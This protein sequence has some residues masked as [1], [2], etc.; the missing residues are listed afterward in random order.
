MS[1]ELDNPIIPQEYPENGDLEPSGYI[2]H[3]FHN[4]LG[5]RVR[6]DFDIPEEWIIF[7]N[8][9]QKTLVGQNDTTVPPMHRC[10]EEALKYDAKAEFTQ[11]APRK[12][13][14]ETPRAESFVL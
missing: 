8:I 9:V 3:T 12:I 10:M 7:V 5:D 6:F 1:Q 14:S 4:F 13:K 2:D 11:Q